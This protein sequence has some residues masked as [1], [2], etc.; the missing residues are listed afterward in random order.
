MATPT[1]IATAGAADANSYATVVEA[2]AF[3]CKGYLE[4]QVALSPEF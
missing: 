3:H 4:M 2:D 1:L